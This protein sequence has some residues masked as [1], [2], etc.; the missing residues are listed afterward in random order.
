MGKGDTRTRKGKINKGSF[1]NSRP[2]AR[3]K[4]SSSDKKSN[5]KD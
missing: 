5:Q 2:T 3:N 1:G 4:R